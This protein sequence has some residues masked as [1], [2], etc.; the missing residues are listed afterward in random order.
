MFSLNGILIG[1]GPRK[2]V[3]TFGTVK[4]KR[5]IS[6]GP[7]DRKVGLVDGLN[8]KV[9]AARRFYSTT[10]GLAKASIAGRRVVTTTG[11]VLIRV[12]SR[13][14]RQLLRLGGTNCHLFLLDGAV[15]IR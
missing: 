13:G 15:S 2:Y 12:P 8:I 5:L 3:K 9:V 10:H 11:G 6:P 4:V 1:L 7:R 14:G